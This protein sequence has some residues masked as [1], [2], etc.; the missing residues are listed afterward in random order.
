MRPRLLLVISLLFLVAIEGWRAHAAVL[1][2]AAGRQT[3]RGSWSASSRTG[4][5]LGGT[6]TATAD[7]KT[8]SVTGAWTLIDEKGTIVR[9]GAWSAAKSPKGWTGA[10]RAAVSGSKGEYAGTWSADVDL[11]PDV[12]FAD[13]FELAVK[14]VVSGAWQVGRQ[15]GAWSI[16]AS[17]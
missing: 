13:L 7:P 9:R 3:V 4:L 17:D 1:Q 2:D 5:T 15:S 12:R 10:W 8:G 6:W 16:R 11:E 14:T